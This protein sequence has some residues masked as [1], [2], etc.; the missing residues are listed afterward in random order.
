VILGQLSDY[1]FVSVQE[2]VKQCLMDSDSFADF[3]KTTV[4][5]K[6]DAFNSHTGLSMN[7]K[8]VSFCHSAVQTHLCNVCRNDYLASSLFCWFKH[9]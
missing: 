9:S 2:Q 8:I 3:D 1:R 4:D 7:Y 6:F 5:N